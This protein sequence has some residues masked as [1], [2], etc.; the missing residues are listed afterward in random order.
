[1]FKKIMSLVLTLTLMCGLAMP[2]F[3]ATYEEPTDKEAVEKYIQMVYAQLDKDATPAEIAEYTADS[4]KAYCDMYAV[5][6]DTACTMLRKELEAG[7]SLDKV[8]NSQGFQT[9]SKKALPYS[10][11]GDI[12]FVDSSFWWNHVGMYTSYNAIVEA[13]PDDQVHYCS[14]SSPDAAQEPVDNNNDS[15]IL[16][17]GNTTYA[18]KAV[19]WVFANVPDGTPYDA[20]FI[21]NKGDNEMSALNC[22]ELVWRAYKY[23]AGIDLDSNGGLGVYPNDIN[24]SPLLKVVKYLW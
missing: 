7:L 15:R 13:M 24:E 18:N 21:N 10:S 4:I 12:F 6:A 9:I 2:A 22:S 23:G 3:A 20:D 5:D 8:E 19:A 1:M 14:T 17:T 16:T 11:K